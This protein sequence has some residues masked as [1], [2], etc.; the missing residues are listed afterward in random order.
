MWLRWPI[1][2]TLSLWMGGASACTPAPPA[3]PLEASPPSALPWPSPGGATEDLWIHILDV[4]QGDALLIQEPMGRQ[5]LVD[6]GPSARVVEG[7]RAL[8]VDTLDLFIASH[9]H[10]DHIGGAAAVLD[11]FP[12]RFY[13]DNG[14]A[15]TTVTYQRTLEA[16]ARRD[17]PLLEPDRRALEIGSLTLEIFPPSGDPDWGHNAN[18]IGIRLERGDFSAFF[19]GDAEEPLWSFW[20][21]RFPEAFLPVDLLKGSHH[22]SRNGDTAEALGRLRPR[23]VVISAGRDNAYGHPHPEALDRYRALGAEIHSTAEEGT[24]HIRVPREGSPEVFSSRGPN[25]LQWSCPTH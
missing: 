25:A 7:L 16:L 4:G 15:H 5:V 19:A 2:L 8:C 11:A 14:V 12:V 20:M 9:N 10:A 24:L 17:T 22:G 23:R 18:S 3:A 1:G 21:N 6:A 13:L